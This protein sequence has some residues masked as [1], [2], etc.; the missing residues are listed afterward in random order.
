MIIMH[1]CMPYSIPY[2][3]QCSSMI[4]NNNRSKTSRNSSF[5]PSPTCHAVL[6]Y[7]KITC[8]LNADPSR[9]LGFTAPGMKCRNISSGFRHPWLQ[10]TVHQLYLPL[11]WSRKYGPAHV[12]NSGYPQFYGG[13]LLKKT[14]WHLLQLPTTRECGF[15]R[16]KAMAHGKCLR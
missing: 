13:N 9:H 14:K 3:T 5:V 16:K 2:F 12:Q 1:H 11:T 10:S 15:L 7:Q 6:P 8:M 4:W